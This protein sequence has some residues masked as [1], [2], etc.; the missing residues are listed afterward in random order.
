MERILIV[1][2]EKDIGT[3]L[4]SRFESEGF[5]CLLAQNGKEAIELAKT[6]HPSL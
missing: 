1:D 2:D 5:E 4:K 3:L 6:K